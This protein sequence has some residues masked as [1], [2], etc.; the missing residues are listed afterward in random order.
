[1]L[2][3]DFQVRPFELQPEDGFVKK[4]KRVADLIIF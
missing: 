1:M 2:P 4:P 3:M